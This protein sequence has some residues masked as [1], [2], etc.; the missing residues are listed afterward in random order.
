MP[1]SLQIFD[2]IARIYAGPANHSEGRFSY[3]NRSARPGVVTIRAALQEW[4]E[5]Y[6]QEH[7]SEL[8]ARFRSG[9]DRNFDSAFFELFLHE[10]LLRLKCKV[11][12]HP[13]PP[14][15]GG[16]APDFLVTPEN[17]EQFYLEAI[18]AT[19]MSTEEAA[20]QAVIDL[21]YDQIDRLESP[22][23]FISI[24]TM[25]GVATRQPSGKRIRVFLEERLAALDPDEVAAEYT[26]RQRDLPSWV[27]EEQGL[28]IE[29]G[30]VPKSPEGRLKEGGRAIGI[31]GMKTRWGSDAP[32]LRDAVTKKGGRYGDLGL[33]YVVAVN[34]IS[35]WGMEHIDAMEALFGTETFIF[36]SRVS[37]PRMVR[38]PDGAFRSK[39]G[40]TYTRV[41]AVLVAFGAH[42]PSLASLPLRLYHNP[43]AKY[44]YSGP[45]CQLDQAVPEGDT[46]QRVSGTTVAA[47]FGLPPDWPGR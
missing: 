35:E 26:E 12:V 1:T 34:P 45:L 29:F 3:Y 32:S 36:E 13:S 40:P 22:N 43:W 28:K 23:F 18:V 17:G 2:D 30:V 27:Y 47:L 6:P 7:Q 24:G 41:S 25:E 46:M 31:F 16:K 10:L 38:N 44:P 11:E 4:F 37:E 42:P 19:A 39:G 14:G 5:R 20:R 21:V 15:A 9:N 8:R 33:P